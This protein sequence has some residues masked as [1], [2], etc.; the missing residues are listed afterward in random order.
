MGRPDGTDTVSLDIDG[1]GVGGRGGW[2]G[3]VQADGR[4]GAGLAPPEAFGN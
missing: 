2:G 3:A 4:E 1:V